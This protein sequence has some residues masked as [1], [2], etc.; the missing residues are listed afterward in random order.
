VNNKALT[1]HITR[2]GRMT[3]RSSHSGILA[4]GARELV[5]R[6]T[7]AASETAGWPL[8]RHIWPVC[9]RLAMVW[10]MAGL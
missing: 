5:G 10:R 7:A 4:G 1:E 8:L 6:V 9:V 2:S 3:G